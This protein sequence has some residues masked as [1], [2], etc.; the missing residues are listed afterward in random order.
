M[1]EN[2]ARLE[3]KLHIDLGMKTTP[4]AVAVVIHREFE[5]TA[6]LKE[7]GPCCQPPS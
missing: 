6:K 2:N 3:S 7:T 1:N 4:K 5:P